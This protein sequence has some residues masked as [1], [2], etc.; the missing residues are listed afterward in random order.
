MK[1]ITG[2]LLFF[3]V[4]AF[5]SCEGPQGPPGMDGDAII[6]TV[7]E[8]EDD[9]TNEND[10]MLFYEFPSNFEIIDGDAVFVYILWDQEAETDIWRLLPQTLVLE[11]GILQYNYDYTL[12]DVKIF[13]DGDIDFSTLLPAETDNQVFRIVV[14]PADLVASKSL[15]ITDLSAVMKSAN[16]SMNSIQKVDLK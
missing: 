11:S 15:D 16:I 9:F 8:F 14:L 1:T 4:V 12:A 7:F 10:Y 13:I 2:I 5:T 3:T 6:G